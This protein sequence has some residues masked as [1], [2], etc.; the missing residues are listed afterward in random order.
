MPDFADAWHVIPVNDIIEHE[1]TGDECPCGPRVD[2]VRREDGSVGWVIV[3]HS[4]D[5]RELTE[6]K[7]DPE[8]EEQ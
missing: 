2:P 3:H 7:F 5:G 6:M 1:D 4:L 8:E